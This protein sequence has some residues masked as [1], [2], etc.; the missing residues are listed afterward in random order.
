M[1]MA[2]AGGSTSALCWRPFTMTLLCGAAVARPDEWI[3]LAACDSVND[4]Q[5]CKESFSIGE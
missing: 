2:A 5:D 4:W 3:R 1:D